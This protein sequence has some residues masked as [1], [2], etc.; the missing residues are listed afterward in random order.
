M[1]TP[2]KMLRSGPFKQNRQ[3]L[4]NVNP[5][6]GDLG[7][8]YPVG[9][10]INFSTDEDKSTTNIV[11]KPQYR[12]GND[13]AG[14]TFGGNIDLGVT[15][16]KNATVTTEKNPYSEFYTSTASEQGYSLAD[17]F[18]TTTQKQDVSRK[19]GGEV[20]FDFSGYQDY[21]PTIL[22]DLTIGAGKEFK[23]SYTDVKKG[24]GTGFVY[25]DSPTSVFPIVVGTDVGRDTEYTDESKSTSNYFGGKVSLGIGNTA[26]AGETP[27]NIKAFAKHMTTDLKEKG[28]T[29]F[30]VSGRYKAL[31]SKIEIGDDHKP[32]FSIGASFGL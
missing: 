26:N 9:S 29:T 17:R 1:I 16:K 27:W 10:G 21:A 3:S 23:T 31:T 22:G 8:F 28:K 12:A 24:G 11:F 19:F 4:F 18:T 13:Q 14:I 20:K 7:G 32:R 2:F 15:N 6:T 25:E 5:D 30:G